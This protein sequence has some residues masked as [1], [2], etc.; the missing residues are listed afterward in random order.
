MSEAS[1][2]LQRWLPR[3]PCCVCGVRL[4]HSGSVR[5]RFSRKPLA[6][7]DRRACPLQGVTRNAHARSASCGGSCLA[8]GLA[9]SPRP[10]AVHFHPLDEDCLARSEAGSPLGRPRRARRVP[11]PRAN[12]RHQPRQARSEK[13]LGITLDEMSVPDCVTVIAP[14][15]S[16]LGQ[17]RGPVNCRMCNDE[18]VERVTR[19]AKAHRSRCHR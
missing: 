1:P 9:P 16:V 18:P 7:R 11:P 14:D 4:Q 6:M 5:G 13:A 10:G 12:D 8:R 19:P 3:T 2:P 15:Q 17:Q